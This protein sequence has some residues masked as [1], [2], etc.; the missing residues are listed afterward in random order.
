MKRYSPLC[1]LIFTLLYIIAC[2][3][4]PPSSTA[5][6]AGANHLVFRCLEGEGEALQT[7]PLERCGC[8]ETS[9]DTTGQRSLTALDRES[10]LQSGDQA[11]LIAYLASETQG[12]I[13][14]LDLGTSH[15]ILDIDP[16]IPGVTHVGV[17]GL[18]STIQMHPY[19]DFL[20]LLQGSQGVLSLLTDHSSVRPE[21]SLDLGYGPL[22]SLAVW[23]K[24]NEPLPEM[25]SA[26]Y[27]YVFAPLEGRVLEI[28]LDALHLALD[29]ALK[30][31]SSSQ[32]PYLTLAEEDYIA[33][34]WHLVDE[35]GTPLQISNLDVDA[36]GEHLVLAHT[37]EPA[38]TVID[39]TASPDDL[40]TRRTINYRTIDGC[41]D[42]YLRSTD[43]ECMPQT[44]WLGEQIPACADGIDN[45]E[46][47]FIDRADLGCESELDQDE[48][49]SNE[50]SSEA[51]SC[52][53]GLDN[54]A[55]GLI[56][57]EDPGCR[58]PETVSRF[59]FEQTP[60]CADGIDNDLD[61]LLD[62]DANGAGDPDCLFAADQS[63]ARDQVELGT[64]LLLTATLS[65]PQGPRSFAY[66][67][68]PQGA[69]I[70][71]DLDAQELTAVQISPKH[72][73]IAI[74]LRRTGA[75][76]SLF[77]ITS[78]STLESVHLTAPEPLLTSLNEPVYAKGTLSSK[79]NTFEVESFYR[80]Q[81]QRAYQLSALAPWVGEIEI[82]PHTQVPVLPNDAIKTL[83][84]LGL[85]T[86]AEPELTLDARR[87]EGD[88]QVY[89]GLGRYPLYQA[90]WNRIRDAAGQ[91]PRVLTPP[92]LSFNG[93]PALFNPERHPAFCRLIRPRDFIG[94]SMNE[95]SASCI[96]V[97][98]T[99]GG[100]SELEDDRKRRLASYINAYEGIFVKQRDP[101]KEETPSAFSIQFEGALPNSLSQ[102]GA[103]ASRTE[104]DWNLIDYEA[105]FCQIGVEPGDLLVVEAFKPLDADA[106]ADPAC[107][108]YL[109]RTPNE[110]LQPLRYQVLEVRQRGLTLKID[111]RDTYEPQLGLNNATIAA[112]LSPALPPPPAHC[113]APSF[114]YRIHVA[115]DEWIVTNDLYGYQ[116][117]WISE[118][119][120]CVT[121][122]QEYP[123][124]ARARLGELYQDA[125]V[126]FQLGYRAKE[127]VRLGVAE[128]RLPMMVGAR[129][130]FSVNAGYVTQ[131]LSSVGL[132][133]MELRWLPEL[134][135]LY[136]VDAATE[137]AVEFDQIDPYTGFMRQVQLFD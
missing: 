68:S 70:S 4:S 82:D 59:A 12:R 24:P 103:L 128:G 71:I 100:L 1:S 81:G 44:V 66:A 15:Q 53:D 123:Q 62:Y 125:W 108:N 122:R 11:K 91:T 132:L 39:L 8:L 17:D 48:A 27:A 50:L 49:Q 23:P 126:I 19:G 92:S 129:F 55:D 119:G 60:Q 42:P 112:K 31:N 106:T 136:V 47:G 75:L 89:L 127:G 35:T 9:L 84:E 94:E 133:P 102:S 137:S 117:P 28:D 7:Y 113:I 116:H 86:F 29:Q 43:A 101:Q 74:E 37:D 78:K 109:R 34:S 107:Q 26:S 5:R 30:A 54:D 57:D 51:D 130:D 6:L 120:K 79:P 3:T 73:P 65:L 32:D 22:V 77:Y 99:E 52:S 85:A 121:N 83:K 25:G 61:G 110:G 134:D 18:I 111:D 118:G 114:N 115:A 40:S 76:A 38:L 13:A 56:D 90:P 2:D 95:E 64:P 131:R 36:R 10:C 98:D 97:G 67:V 124:H 88:L 93:V 105:D 80:V 45:D 21:R 96:L 135:R 14:T 87:G 63:E 16:T 104:D 41:Q 46:D 58:D 20:I 69:L 72:N 33:R